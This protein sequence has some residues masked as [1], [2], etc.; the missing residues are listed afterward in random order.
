MSGGKQEELPDETTLHES[1]R[2][3]FLGHSSIKPPSKKLVIVVKS[4]VD[5]CKIT[6]ERP[7]KLQDLEDILMRRYGMP[8][9]IFHSNISYDY[10]QKINHQSELDNLIRLHDMRNKESKFRLTVSP[11]EE[12]DVILKP[13]SRGV[14]RVG[15]FINDMASDAATSARTNVAS[16][17]MDLSK[18]A[19]LPELPERR[20]P[21]EYKEGSKIGTGAH[22]SVYVCYDFD[23]GEKLVLKKIFARGDANAIK[24]KMDSLR[25]EVGLLSRLSHE[26]IVQYRGAVVADNFVLIFMEFMSG[27]SLYDVVSPLRIVDL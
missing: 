11:K 8:L 10:L 22:G 27:G 24:I 7:V 12:E 5:R 15:D 13:D 17:T 25:D 18:L 9:N 20:P 14:Y 4:E 16:G 19:N 26:N 21:E 2:D 23:T 6:M 1:L 3:L